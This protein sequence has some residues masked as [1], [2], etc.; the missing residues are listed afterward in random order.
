MFWEN[1][2]ERVRQILHVQ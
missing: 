2:K 1:R